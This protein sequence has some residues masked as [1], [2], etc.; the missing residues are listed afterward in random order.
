LTLGSMGSLLAGCSR[1]VLELADRSNQASQIRMGAV[2]EAIM[3]LL[4]GPS[5][6]SRVGTS[7]DA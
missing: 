7:E 6:V 4:P 1:G 3:K 2:S 5:V